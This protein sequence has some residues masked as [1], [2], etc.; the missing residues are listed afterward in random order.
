LRALTQRLATASEIFAYGE[1]DRLAVVAA[2]IA[3]RADFNLEGWRSW[4]TEMDKDDH[5][6]WKDVPP[7]V[8]PLAR[9]ENDSYFMSAV[10]AQIVLRPATNTLSEAQKAI[11]ELLRQR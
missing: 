2:V 10:V 3:S 7:K 5:A 8:L 11:V 1:Q 6:V 9:F 4:I